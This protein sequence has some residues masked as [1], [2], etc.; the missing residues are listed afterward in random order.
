MTSSSD[1]AIPFHRPS[2]GDAEREAV[3]EVLD[4]GWL[5][6]GARTVEFERAFAEFAAAIGEK[7]GLAVHLLVPWS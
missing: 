6:T 2:L 3:I 5:T 1:E 7:F 4:S